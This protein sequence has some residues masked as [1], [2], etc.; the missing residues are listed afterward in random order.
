M[1]YNDAVKAA[2]GLRERYDAPYNDSDKELVARLYF[3]VLGKVF[4]PTTCQTCYH[5]AAIEIYCY[6]KTNK[7]MR[8]KCNYRL[9]AGFII[10]CPDF[11]NGK[12]FTNENLTDKVAKEYLEKYPN[13]ED[14][15]Q[16]LP[17][18]DGENE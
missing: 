14:Y 11:Y 8:K 13:M 7:S 6:L 10:A 15:F 9:R 17:D 16:K 2:E 1:T 3:D 5:D 4:K 12:I 18:E